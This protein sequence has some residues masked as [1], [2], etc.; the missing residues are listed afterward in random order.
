MDIAIICA[1]LISLRPLLRKFYP[2]KA[3]P[4]PVSQHS[5]DYCVVNHKKRSAT[6]MVHALSD[7]AADVESIVSK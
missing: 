4:R 3:D 6:F 5:A 7:A 1:C 2:P